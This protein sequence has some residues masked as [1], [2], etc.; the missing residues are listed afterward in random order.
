MKDPRFAKFVLLVNGLVPLGIL[1]FD[2]ATGN[3]GAN[4]TENM[5]H[6]TGVMALVFLLL[7][8]AVTP[9]RRI[10]GYNF[11]SHFRR[12]LGLFAFFYGCLHLFCYFKFDREL[13]FAG[14]IADVANKPFIL[15]GMAALLLMAPLA[16]TSTNGM[17][18]R[19]GANRWKWL[20]RL[21]YP[22]AVLAV[23]HFWMSKKS[24]KSLPQAFAL[25]LVVLLGYRL[26][27]VFR[28]RKNTAVPRA[29]RA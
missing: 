4:P 9:A 19:L 12:M 2:V 14:M 24:D 27:A 17:I 5:I 18:K 11:L 26:I 8:L 29:A 6:T 21:V 15:L 3:A 23:I 1:C 10:S 22:V 25:V 7:S 20:H 28:S 13:S 16:A